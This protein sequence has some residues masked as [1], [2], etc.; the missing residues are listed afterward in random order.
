MF[1]KFLNSLKGSHGESNNKL[2]DKI[3]KMDL[4]EM[5]IYVNDKL[6]D[7]EVDDFGLH[8]V[9]KK[10]ITRNEESS[11]Y[12]L[13][14]N[15]LDSKKKKA[16]ELLLLI[17]QHKKASIAVLESAQEFLY[18]YNKLIKQY[19]KDNKDIYESKIKKL[20]SL[21]VDRINMETNI[22][23]VMEVSK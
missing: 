4:V 14:E 7:F 15:D 17:L 16:F 21:A 18:V 2:L 6:D 23:N 8:E 12:F 5:R 9:V 3:S 13:Q 19:D 10:L 22:I 11:K 20:M 1:S